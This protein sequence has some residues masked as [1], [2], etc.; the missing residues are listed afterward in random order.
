MSDLSRTTNTAPAAQHTDDTPVRFGV[1][2]A[3]FIAR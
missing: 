1:I 2:G 3:G